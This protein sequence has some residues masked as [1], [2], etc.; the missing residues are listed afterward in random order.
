MVLGVVFGMSVLGVVLSLFYVIQSVDLFW[1]CF[2][3]VSLY[4]LEDG[5]G[6]GLWFWD[7]IWNQWVQYLFVHF[8]ETVFGLG[9][10]VSI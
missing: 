3:L 2:H 5:M 10:V 4:L 8:T 9:F 1:Y 7:V 6:L